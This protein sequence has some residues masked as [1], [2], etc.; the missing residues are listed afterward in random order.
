MEIPYFE[1][2]SCFDHNEKT[3]VNSHYHNCYEL[4]YY[5]DGKGKSLTTN[6]TLSFTTGDFIIYKPGEIHNEIHEKPVSVACIGFKYD[7]FNS[8]LNTGVYSD[9]NKSVYEIVQRIRNEMGGRRPRYNLMINFL[10][11]EL[12][13]AVLRLS[14][15]GSGESDDIYYIKKYMDENYNI[16]FDMEKLAEIS[17][18]SYHHFRHL[19]KQKT[20]LS[21]KAYIIKQKIEHAKLLL[22]EGKGSISKIAL[23]CNFSDVSQF[24]VSFKKH[25]GRTPNEYRKNFSKT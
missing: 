2:L 14:E 22:A 13:I 3:E 4:V 20:S 21:P 1:Y 24:S 6:K 5:Y 23:D 11:A 12:I 18:Y 10:V 8:N 15:K 25:T 9:K 17:G 19:F 7:S 16:N